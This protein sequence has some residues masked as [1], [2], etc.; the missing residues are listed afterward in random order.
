[1][2]TDTRGFIPKPF[3]KALFFK[4]IPE[5]QKNSLQIFVK[6]HLNKSPRKAVLQKNFPIQ[7]Q[8]NYIIYFDILK[9]SMIGRNLQISFSEAISRK[10]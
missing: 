7:S 6:E 2:F 3:L 9:S 8:A 4:R 10:P 5:T 1:M